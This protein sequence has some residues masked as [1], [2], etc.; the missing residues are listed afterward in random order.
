MKVADVGPTFLS[1]HLKIDGETYGSALDYIYYSPAFEN[2]LAI[3]SLKNSASDHL[4]I[5]CEIRSISKMLPYTHQIT[6]ICLK[7][8][9]EERW[10]EKLDMQDW[11][12]LGDCETVD[13]MV[14][15]LSDNIN[16]ALDSVAPFKKLKRILQILWSAHREHLFDNLNRSLSQIYTLC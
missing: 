1:D 2:K 16:K 8:F 4:P 14:D 9:S 12:E 7:N 13:E 15:I 3:K 10:N 11:S 5:V 6:K